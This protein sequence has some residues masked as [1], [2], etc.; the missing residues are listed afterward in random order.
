MRRNFVNF[1]TTVG[2]YSK[3]LIRLTRNKLLLDSVFR[4][5][6]FVLGKTNMATLKLF[7]YKINSLLLSDLKAYESEPK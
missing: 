2:A 5:T 6:Y 7:S 4:R 1:C 3:M